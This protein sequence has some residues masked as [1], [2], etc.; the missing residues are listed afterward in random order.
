MS[1]HFDVVIIGSGAGGGTMA[2]AL[3][4]TPARI[5]VVER[6]DFVPQENENW[7]PEAVWK[8]LRY[9]ADERWLD[10]HGKAFLPYTH[11]CVGGNT[12]FWG[13]VAVPPAA[14]RFPGRRAC[15]RDLAGLAHRL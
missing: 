5:L 12:K 13:S 8:H 15:R 10:E 1:E 4:G 9:R 11:Y 2:Q 6:G 7:N 14:R 3:S